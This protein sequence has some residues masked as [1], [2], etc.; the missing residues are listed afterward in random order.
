M[1][2]IFGL[3]A[4]LLLLT[5]C[6]DG[7]MTF[8]SFNFS[9]ANIQ[10]C[11][12]YIFKVQGTEAMIMQLNPSF[13]VNV[14]TGATPR[15]VTIGSGNSM[16]YRTYSDNVTSSSICSSLPPATPVVTDEYY[17]MPGGTLNVAT[18]KVVNDEGRIT[19]YNHTIT[20]VYATFA[21]DGE[22]I[23]I[24]DNVFGVYFTPVTY[25]FDFEDEDSNINLQSCPEPPAFAGKVFTVN[26]NE[27]LLFDLDILSFP[28]TDD[29]VTIIDFSVQTETQEIIFNEYSGTAVAPL[30][31][32]VVPPITPVV[33]RQWEAIGGKLRIVTD[34]VAGTTYEHVLYLDNVTFMNRAVNEEQFNVNVE[35]GYRIG[36]LTLVN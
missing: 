17:A 23:I 16:I 24:N 13:F 8:K 3:F 22:S 31:C 10:T 2:K 7:D 15:T 18:V 35:G 6:D 36:K 28:E 5:G 11:N 32:D 25:R 21:K 20:I 19:G 4:S 26:G 12:N 30:F 14:E 29:T 1:K 33:T 9:G 27:A 34:V